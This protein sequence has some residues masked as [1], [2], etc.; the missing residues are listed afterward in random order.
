[1]HAEREG[2]VQKCPLHGL[3][4]CQNGTFTVTVA[5]ASQLTN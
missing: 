3:D 4:E 5:A 2:M 1:M